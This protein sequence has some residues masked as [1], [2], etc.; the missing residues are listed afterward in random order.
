MNNASNL[1]SVFEVAEIQILEM[2]KRD[3][4]AEITEKLHKEFDVLIQ[5]AITKAFSEMTFRLSRERNTM[6]LCDQIHVLVEWIKCRE[7]KRKFK[8]V[9]QVAE[10]TN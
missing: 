6:A 4:R 7:E 3:I 9:S 1:S 10:L 8:T 2:I 5:D